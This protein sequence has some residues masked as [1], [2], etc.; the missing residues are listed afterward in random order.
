M[1]LVAL[2]RQGEDLLLLQAA[3]QRF[4]GLGV[5]LQLCAEAIHDQVALG[6][7]AHAKVP[8][9]GREA[10][11]VGRRGQLLPVGPEGEPEM[12]VHRPAAVEPP[13]VAVDAG[14]MEIPVVLRVLLLQMRKQRVGQL[15]GGPVHQALIVL[16]V[17]AEPFAAVVQPELPEEIHRFR[18]IVQ[19][20]SPS[21]Y[22]PENGLP[23]GRSGSPWRGVGIS[24]GCGSARASPDRRA[25]GR[26]SAF[27]PWPD[28]LRWAR[29]S[30]RRAAGSAG[31]TGCPRGPCCSDR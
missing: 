15:L 27:P 12:V 28:S 31:H 17:G 13:G 19:H 23:S 8:A 26:G 24:G 20:V 4:G 3:R 30:R 11:P 22:R 25:A 1:L 2:A 10:E 9:L 14:D 29:C 16:L 7:A 5:Q 21:L 18:R 6:P